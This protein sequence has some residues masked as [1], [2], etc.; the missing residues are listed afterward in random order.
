MNHE[1]DLDRISR[2]PSEAVLPLGVPAASHPHS[3]IHVLFAAVLRAIESF[4]TVMRRGF[5]CFDRRSSVV[6]TFFPFVLSEHRLLQLPLPTPPIFVPTDARLCPL[7][8]C[9]NFCSEVSNLL[10]LFL[11]NMRCV[12]HVFQ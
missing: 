2:I 6:Y 10:R 1:N 5:D 4:C 11:C 3:A 7:K 9:R 12:F 8:V